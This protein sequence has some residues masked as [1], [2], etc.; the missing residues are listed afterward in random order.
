MPGPWQP[1]VKKFLSPGLDQEQCRKMSMLAQMV[2]EARPK[3]E[4]TWDQIV[5]PQYHKWKKVFSKEEL[6]QIPQHQPWDIGIDLQQTCLKCSTANLPL[7]T[8][9]TREAQG[10][11][12]ITPQERIYLP[13]K[14]T[15]HIFFLLC[16]KK[17]WKIV[18]SG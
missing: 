7:D 9:R 5:P 8:R 4:K 1:L 14:I 13:I 11:H 3:E 10:V 2:A 16:W 18:P 17:G 15:I 12:Q 6:N